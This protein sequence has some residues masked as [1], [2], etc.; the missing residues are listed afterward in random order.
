[1]CIYLFT[2]AYT[3]SRFSRLGLISRFSFSLSLSLAL[4]LLVACLETPEGSKRAPLVLGT[5]SLPV[6]DPFR[7]PTEHQRIA[8]V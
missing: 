2:L 4:S 7:T 6:S 8:P 3:T 5:K 1:M